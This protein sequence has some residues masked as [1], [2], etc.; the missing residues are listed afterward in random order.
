MPRTADGNK[1][2]KESSVGTNE[3]KKILSDGEVRIP[4]SNKDAQIRK[5]ESKSNKQNQKNQ[6]RKRIKIIEDS[7]LNGLDENLMK[8]YHNV[9]V[10][11]Y[12][13]ANTHDIKEHIKSIMRRTP[14]CVIIHAG[15]ND[16]KCLCTKILHLDFISK[17]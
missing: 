7:I 13:G 16:L 4:E 5:R 1:G 17:S 3:R 9:Q 8:R 6:E 2:A 10:R 12:S 15:T 11:A 14:D